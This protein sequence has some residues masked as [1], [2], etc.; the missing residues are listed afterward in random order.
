MQHVSKPQVGF[1]NGQQNEE[2]FLTL[3][4]QAH[5]F[6]SLREFIDLNEWGS[7]DPYNLPYRQLLNAHN[8]WFTRQRD[9]M[10]GSQ[11]QQERPFNHRDHSPRF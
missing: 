9:Q 4:K 6:M 10:A 3:S 1:V 11:A 2:H 5:E 7:V 8:E